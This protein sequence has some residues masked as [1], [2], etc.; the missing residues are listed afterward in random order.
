MSGAQQKAISFEEIV[1][2]RDATVRV[3]EDKMIYAV[4]LVMVVTGIFYNM[5][6]SHVIFCYRILINRSG[7]S[8]NPNK[9]IWFI[10]EF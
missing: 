5:L 3:T 1:S 7:L 9:P 4:D 2:G 10:N 6:L 8:G